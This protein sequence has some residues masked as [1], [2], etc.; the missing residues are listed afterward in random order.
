MD[1]IRP[2]RQDVDWL[3]LDLNSFFAS[4]E[5]EA[6]P[7]LRGKYVGVVPLVDVDTTCLLAASKEAKRDYGLKTGTP[8]GEAKRRCPDL[9]L[10]HAS[11]KKYGYYHHKV[12]EIIESCTPI[13]K[14]M[15]IDEVACELTG[16]QRRPENALALAQNIKAKIRKE[17]YSLTSSIGI[18]PNI[19]LAKVASDMMKPDGLVMIRPCDLPD[20]LLPLNLRDFSGIGPGMEQRLNR[21]GIYSV[22]DLYGCQ[23]KKLRAIWGGVEGERFHAKL[24]GHNVNREESKKT[25]MGHQHVL[26]PHLRNR[27]SAYHVL[28]HLLIKAVERLRHVD[29]YCKRLSLNVKMDR[30]QGYWD[31]E[32]DFMETRDTQFLLNIMNDLWR[33]YPGQRPLRVGIMLHGLVPATA[34]QQDLFEKRRP[35]HLCSALDDINKKFGRHTISFGL[36]PYVQ[37]KVGRDKIAFQRVPENVYL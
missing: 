4:C 34:H 24:W 21:G 12:L 28:H 15:S 11:H 27:E 26:E 23:P 3:V 32:T 2:T 22:K 6:D 8:V 9:V 36:N 14:V 5:Q 10:I 30:H 16:S 19:L 37:E 7:A 31:R 18:A 25:V 33:G 13:Q 1:W 20:M 29:Y 35:A 17:F